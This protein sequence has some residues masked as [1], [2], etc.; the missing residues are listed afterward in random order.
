MKDKRKRK[1]IIYYSA[2]TT[3]H[4]VSSRVHGISVEIELKLDYHGLK[5]VK[6]IQI[7]HLIGRWDYHSVKTV[8]NTDR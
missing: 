6:Y 5:K 3:I 2:F 7:L 1:K 4:W 8:L